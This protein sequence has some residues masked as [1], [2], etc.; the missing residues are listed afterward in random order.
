MEIIRSTNYRV[1]LKSLHELIVSI[2]KIYWD[3]SDPIFYK[4][5]FQNEA[6]KDGWLQTDLIAQH[7]YAFR[8]VV[9]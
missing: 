3:V 9:H 1:N 8:P 2:F 5:F 4:Y 6:F 7:P